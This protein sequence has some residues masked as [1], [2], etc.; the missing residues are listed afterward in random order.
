V[1][2]L[3][4]SVPRLAARVV[5][6]PWTVAARAVGL[7]RGTVS[8]VR[9][10]PSD[11]LR[12]GSVT[13]DTSAPVPVNVQEELGLDA[14]PVDTPRVPRTPPV[15]SIDEQAEPDLVEST[16]ADV[17]ARLQRTEDADRGD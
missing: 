13:P 10:A 7:A 3:L 8:V 17:A 11:D 5:T 12:P 1:T 2:H 9:G 6:L 16:P 15:T 4:P 14:A